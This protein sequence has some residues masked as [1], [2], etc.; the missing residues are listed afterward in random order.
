VPTRKSARERKMMEQGEAY[1][2][3]VRER[4]IVSE[5]KFLKSNW[6]RLLGTIR[7]YGNEVSRHRYDGIDAALKTAREGWNLNVYVYVYV[8]WPYL[9]D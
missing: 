4:K 9:K 5:Q 3:E 8:Y 7:E 2:R 1:D 6:N